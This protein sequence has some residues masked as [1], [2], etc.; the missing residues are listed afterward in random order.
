MR[1]IL[2]FTLLLIFSVSYTQEA[3]K[4]KIVLPDT[5]I[6]I[7][8][9]S[10]E[11]IEKKEEGKI[12]LK[13]E[14]IDIEELSKIQM[15][16][17]FKEEIEKEKKDEFSVSSLQFS[18]G[19]YENFLVNMQTARKVT[20]FSYFVSFLR[21][22]RG[23]V[24]FDTNIYFNTER[25]I[26][27]LYLNIE[28]GVTKDFSLSLDAG[29]YNRILGLFTNENVINENKFYIPLKLKG[30]FSGEN[31]LNIKG[32]VN[33]QYLN[34][35]HKLKN[36]YQN[37]NL[38]EVYTILGVEKTWGKDNFLTG[39]ISYNYAYVSKDEHSGSFVLRDRF[40]ILPYLSIQGAF[41]IYFYNYKNFFWFP[42]VMI[43][44]KILENLNFKT[45]MSGGVDFQKSQVL[46]NRNEIN[47]TDFLPDE[48][49]NYSA[50]LYYRPIEKLLIG[51]DG[52]Y[53]YY[54]NFRKINFDN[55]FKLYYI[56]NETN[57]SI[58]TISPFV[59]YN[60]VEDLL[61]SLGSKIRI[62]D[63]NKILLLND[64]EVIFKLS[65]YF[66]LIGLNIENQLSYIGPQNIGN[67]EV[68][69]SYWKWN[70][71]LSQ[72]IH[73]SLMLEARFNNILNQQIFNGINLPES[74]FSFDLGL[75][76]KF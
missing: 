22:S 58:F 69:L 32:D 34:I 8:D 66:S 51:I 38:Y 50:G 24:G 47:Y 61:L 62:F 27:D 5:P 11:N 19:M 16:K 68:T 17:K 39:E 26:D 29:Y 60:I 53:D 75:T 36:N 14:N 37:T 41:G 3:S 18:Y 59:N 13:K 21:N 63:K 48:K 12:E 71:F 57:I 33:F 1:N 52:V 55:N 45:G 56:D 40:P 64:Y 28:Y 31:F 72:K 10:K 49:W 74:G 42:E 30:E 4:G 9:E 6:V 65:Y 73:D 54:Y 43:F 20:N 67:E 15:S 44:Y 35:K 23:S 7:E 46:L 25:A 2:F 70:I 76:F